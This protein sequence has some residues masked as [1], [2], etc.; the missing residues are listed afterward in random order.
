MHSAPL[1]L[2]LE[3]LRPLSFLPFLLPSFL[4]NSN[5]TPPL[6]NLHLPPHGF[7]F[8]VQIRS[9]SS[10]LSVIPLSELLFQSSV[11]PFDFS[12]EKESSA[13]PRFGKESV[14]D[15]SSDGKK[16][17]GKNKLEI[18]P[19]DGV[20]TYKRRRLLKNEFCNTEVIVCVSDSC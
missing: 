4:S 19:E 13:N 15:M 11:P 5:L 16:V 1:S 10:V 2:P 17:L 12:P 3:R 14:G 7:S 8:Q 20:I 9:I 18:S 6:R